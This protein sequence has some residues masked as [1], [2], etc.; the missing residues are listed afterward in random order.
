M[1][2][3]G[4]YPEF[5]GLMLSSSDGFMYALFFFLGIT[6]FFL[7]AKKERSN[8]QGLG[9]HKPHIKNISDNRIY[10][11]FLTNSIT[12]STC[13]FI[14]ISRISFTSLPS[15]PIIKV[16]RIVIG[17]FSTSICICFFFISTFLS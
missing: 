14:S 11:K 10:F 5:I 8:V 7:N 17:L 15:L 3:E 9:L 1:L 12:S 16:E 6:S 13:P 4:F 2:F